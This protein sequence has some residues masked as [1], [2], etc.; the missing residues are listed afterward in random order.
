MYLRNIIILIVFL[1]INIT[2]SSIN[3]YNS[4][5]RKNTSENFTD[6]DICGQFRSMCEQNCYLNGLYPEQCKCN[7]KYNCCL[8]SN[9]CELDQ[10]QCIDN[11]K[12]NNPTNV[13]DLYNCINGC[14]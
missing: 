5:N 8:D 11:C 10:W 12:V 2:I 7:L 1:L 6:D 3:L 4:E 9:D 13:N 14:M